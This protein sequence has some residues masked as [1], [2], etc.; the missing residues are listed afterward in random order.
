[1]IWHGI[2][3][4]E[5]SEVGEGDVSLCIQREQA[6]IEKFFSAFYFPVSPCIFLDVYFKSKSFLEVYVE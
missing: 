6:I 5:V 4:M 1:L 3:R 2:G